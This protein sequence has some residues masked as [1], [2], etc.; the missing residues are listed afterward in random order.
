MHRI[1]RTGRAGE[2]GVAHTFFT[3]ANAKGAQNLLK[4]LREAKQEIPPELERLSFGPDSES[5]GEW[6]SSIYNAFIC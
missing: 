2:K 5:G 3:A 6:E 4:V 1:G